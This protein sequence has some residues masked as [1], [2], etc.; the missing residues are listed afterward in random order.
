MKQDAANQSNSSSNRQP[1]GSDKWR[2]SAPCAKTEKQAYAHGQLGFSD[3]VSCG[4]IFV[5][6]NKN[7]ISLT[8]LCFFKLLPHHF[9]RGLLFPP[10]S[11]LLFPQDFFFFFK[12]FAFLD[13]Q[14]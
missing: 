4:Y 14:S 8:L 9:F 13:L 3:N 6:V 10:G 12:F 2:E 11:F 7:D 1:E 5:V